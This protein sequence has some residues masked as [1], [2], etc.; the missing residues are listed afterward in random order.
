MHKNDLRYNLSINNN[1]QVMKITKIFKV[2]CLA[3]KRLIAKVASH[4]ILDNG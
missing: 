2:F 4:C 3:E 1:M